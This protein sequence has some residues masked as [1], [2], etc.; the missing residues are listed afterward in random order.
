MN[1][2]R[3]KM[4]LQMIQNKSVLILS[5]SFII[6]KATLDGDSRNIFDWILR[7]HDAFFN[8]IYYHL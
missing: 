8:S 2:S 6:Y 5:L 7:V 1:K 3:T 4:V